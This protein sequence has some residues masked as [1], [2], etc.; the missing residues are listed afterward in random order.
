[1][2]LP[3]QYWSYCSPSANAMLMSTTPTQLQPLIVY[4]ILLLRRTLCFLFYLIKN[5][6][7]GGSDTKVNNYSLFVTVIKNFKERLSFIAAYEAAH[8]GYCFIKLKNYDLKK[9]PLLG[10]IQKEN[11]MLSHRVAL[12]PG[13]EAQRNGGPP[14]NSA[15]SPVHYHFFYCSISILHAVQVPFAVQIEAH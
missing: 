1:M 2:K 5:I 3:F 11:A 13:G 12:K 4:F 10:E 7:R 9:M 14:H 8:G 6:C 15:R